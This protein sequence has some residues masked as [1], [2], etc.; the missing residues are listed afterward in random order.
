LSTITLTDKQNNALK[1]AVDWYRYDN[2]QR[3]FTIAG[4]AGA[5]KST[6]IRFIIEELNLANTQV[7]YCA[8]TGMA[9]G[10]LTKKGNPATT[11][12]RLIYDII[13][14]EDELGKMSFMFTLKKALE[15]GLKLIVVD[16]VSMVTEERLEE[17]GKFG[18]K[19]IATGDNAQ[20]P[21]VAG[22]MNSLLENP[23]VFLDEPL[24]QALDNP[25][26]YVANEVRQGRRVQ[27]GTY[28]DRVQVINK[29]SLTREMFLLADQILACRNNTV[30]GLNTFYRTNILNVRS[31]MPEIG[32]KVI[33][34]KNNWTL[35][36]VENDVPQFLVNGL[37]GRVM[38]TPKMYQ[39]SKTF[40]FDFKPEYFDKEM[41]E[42]VRADML[43]FTDGIRNDNEIYDSYDEYSRVLFFRKKLEKNA[44]IQINK[45][46]YAYAITV[47][48]S[49]GNEFDNVLYVDEFIRKDLYYK[50]FYT[51]ATRAKERL[52]IAM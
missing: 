36:E 48:K 3:I 43:Y 27:Y 39:K 31:R 47:Y 37:I 45:F 17:I 12:H 1:K 23:D 38:D 18:I 49:Q 42:Q 28:G 6:L 25:I 34:L 8:Y 5:G 21:P 16:E 35:A 4:V 10:V 29:D 30:N 14:V 20:L 9:A 40:D 46:N 11:I 26:I 19:I 32:E 52:I 13:P 7:A 41:F 24:R 44:Q 22:K 33:C 15:E 51:A 2:D 50:Q